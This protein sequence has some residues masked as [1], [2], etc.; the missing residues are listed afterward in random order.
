MRCPRCRAP[1]IIVERNEIELDHCLECHGVWFDGEE[2]ALLFT[3]LG[4]QDAG[5]RLAEIMAP[6][7]K[8]P[9][10]RALACPRCGRKMDQ[11]AVG[12]GAEV[13]LDRCRRGDGIWFDGGELHA[14]AARL[15]ASGA[16][17]F[18]RAAAFVE[19]VFPRT[20]PPEA[21]PAGGPAAEET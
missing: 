6:R 4:A 15:G 14:V 12:S 9:R 11:V 1:M 5:R 16:E 13:L 2:L 19:E 17:G 21:A 18:A 20:L 8:K 10:E 3:S 7:G